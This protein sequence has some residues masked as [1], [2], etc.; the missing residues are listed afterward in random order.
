MFNRIIKTITSCLFYI[1]L[2]YFQNILQ[3][4]S[5]K[6]QDEYKIM[7]EDRDSNVYVRHIHYQDEYCYTL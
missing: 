2:V 6:T 7:H 5:N 4:L 3:D 1:K